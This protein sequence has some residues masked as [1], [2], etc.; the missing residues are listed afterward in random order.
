M[1]NCLKPARAVENVR[2]VELS[3]AV[4]AK[5]LRTLTL[6]KAKTGNNTLLDQRVNLIVAQNVLSIWSR[7]KSAKFNTLVAQTLLFDYGLTAIKLVTVNTFWA[8]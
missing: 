7:V 5:F 4:F 3:V 8:N 2:D 1:L 6:S